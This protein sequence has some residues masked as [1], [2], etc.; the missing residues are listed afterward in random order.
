[1]KLVE[2]IV[3]RLTDKDINL[4]LDEI[5]SGAKHSDVL[6]HS[7]INEILEEFNAVSDSKILDQSEIDDFN[8]A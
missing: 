4:L 1:M 5:A 6:S 2:K 7:E 3:S 8:T